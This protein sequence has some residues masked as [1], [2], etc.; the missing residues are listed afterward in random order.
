MIPLCAC[1]SFG[2]RLLLDGGKWRINATELAVCA[3]LLI[4]LLNAVLQ[5]E[6]PI[7][8][9]TILNPYNE[10]EFEDDKLSIVDIKAK[11]STGALF[12]IEVQT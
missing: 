6:H 12:I 4:H 8:E 2:P 9:V 1:L 3:D 7:V 10:K 11:D 5:A